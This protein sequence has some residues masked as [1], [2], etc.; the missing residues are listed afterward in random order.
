MSALHDGVLRRFLSHPLTAM[1]ISPVVELI[2]SIGISSVSPSPW[3]LQDRD[4]VLWNVLSEGNRHDRSERVMVEGRMLPEYLSDGT[5]K[6]SSRK[7]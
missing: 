1:L 6:W 5:T 2:E 3:K 7:R 4:S